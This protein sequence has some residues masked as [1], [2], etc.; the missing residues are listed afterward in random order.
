MSLRGPNAS[1]VEKMIGQSLRGFGILSEHLF[2]A[3]AYE[4]RQ[5]Q[6]VTPLDIVTQK[7]NA[8]RPECGQQPRVDGR[9]DIALV[10]KSRGFL[11]CA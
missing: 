8:R 7:R 2:Q 4:R 10:R 1:D 9:K 3:P 6:R 11:A 5:G